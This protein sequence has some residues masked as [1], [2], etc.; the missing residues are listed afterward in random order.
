M[1]TTAL[2]LGLL[3]SHIINDVIKN[4]KFVLSVI[5]FFLLRYLETENLWTCGL[6]KIVPN[7]FQR[8]GPWPIL[9]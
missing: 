9:S 8:I 5:E 6:I 2:S 1:S 7:H 3:F 4:T